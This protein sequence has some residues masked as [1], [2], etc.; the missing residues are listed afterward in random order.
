[1]N[2]EQFNRGVPEGRDSHNRRRSEA[3][4][5]DNRDN[6]NADGQKSDPILNNI[7]KMIKAWC[8]LR[9]P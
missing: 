1:M 2:N 4:P 3:P 7:D 6:R 9:F 5:T 8:I